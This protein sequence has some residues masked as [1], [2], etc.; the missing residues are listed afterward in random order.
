MPIPRLIHPTPVT[1]Q[2]QVANE[3]IFDPVSREPVRQIWK[4]GQG[5]GL[6]TATTLKAQVNWNLGEME[7]PELHPGGPDIKSYGYLLFRI[8]DLK[9]AGL[10]T[11]NGDGT[12]ER[13]IK[14]GDLITRIGITRVKLYVVFFRDTGHYPDQGG[15]TLLE[16]DFQDRQ[17]DA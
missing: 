13:Q 9:K 14:R 15:A 1:I 11:D 2:R 10:M 3:T 17:P 4:E 16:V 8:K 6:G 5:P 12:F 7:R